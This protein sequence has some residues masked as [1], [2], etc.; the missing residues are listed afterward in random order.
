MSTKIDL[1]LDESPDVKHQTKVEN[2]KKRGIEEVAT[3][4]E[5]SKKAKIQKTPGVESSSSFSSEVKAPTTEL[6]T[7]TA[8]PKPEAKTEIKKPAD[9]QKKPYACT[10]C[11]QTFTRKAHLTIHVS[12]FKVFFKHKSFPKIFI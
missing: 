2:S 7:K 10:K 6:E 9:T 11:G 3:K 12:F 5:N 8:T 1:T 4:N